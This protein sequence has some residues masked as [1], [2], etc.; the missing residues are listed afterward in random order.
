MPLAALVAA[1]CHPAADDTEPTDRANQLEQDAVEGRIVEFALEPGAVTPEEIERVARHVETLA[2][3]K[4]AKV[5]VRAAKDD[6]TVITV[7]LWGSNFPDE[8]TLA[9]EMRASFPFMKDAV[10]TIAE[11]DEESAPHRGI[12][13]AAHEEEDPE[14]LQQRII[15]DLRAKGVKGEIVVDVSDDGEGRKV[16]VRVESDDPADAIAV[17][18]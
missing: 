7:E 4:A 11:L 1:A 15:D 3:V 8:D 18:R 13:S 9:R 16:E 17:E 10:I 6:A 5:K 2:D 14:V 12:D